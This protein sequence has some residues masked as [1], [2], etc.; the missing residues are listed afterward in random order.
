MLSVSFWA[1][2][3]VIGWFIN[4]IQDGGEGQKGPPTSASAVTSANVGISPQNLKTFWLSVLIFVRHT[5][6]KFQG[7]T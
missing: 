6:V 1:F 2:S 5:G 4:P 7:H 3:K